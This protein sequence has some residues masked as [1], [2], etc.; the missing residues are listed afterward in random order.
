[1]AC[2][3]FSFFVLAMLMLLFHNNA[4]GK[5]ITLH[6][7]VQSSAREISYGIKKLKAAI[8]YKRFLISG[9]EK[10]LQSAIVWLTLANEFWHNLVEATKPVYQPV[11]LTHLMWNENGR[12]FHWSI[13][14]EQVKE[15]LIR[16][17]SL[18][19]K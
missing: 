9:D 2:F 16:L 18:T 15:E 14:E 5:G 8:E 12:T 17:K 7:D 19:K 10:A 13:I 1:M 3:R 6:L 4:N 11:L